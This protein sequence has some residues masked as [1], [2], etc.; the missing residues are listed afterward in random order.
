MKCSYARPWLLAVSS[1]PAL[2]VAV[3]QHLQDCPD[4]RVQLQ[5]LLCI[6]RDVKNLPVPPESPDA[7][8]RFRMLLQQTP[9]NTASQQPKSASRGR[10]KWDYAVRA[11]AAALLLGVGLGWWLAAHRENV[12]PRDGESTY[13]HGESQIVIRTLDNDLRLAETFAPQEQVQALAGMAGDLHCEALAL[14]K[15]G[16]FDELKQV[17][18]L[19]QQVVRGAIVRRAG[20]LSVQ[21]R[22]V[23]LAPVV[24]QLEEAETA[25][26]RFAAETLPTAGDSLRSMGESAR[27]TIQV[28]QSD[29]QAAPEL[30][31]P[32]RAD[33]SGAL[34]NALVMNG[35][36]LAETDDPLRR[37]DYC[38][39]MAHH[40]V[41]T[42]LQASAKGNTDDASNLGKY[43]GELL[44]RGVA[45]NLDRVPA[46]E[47]VGPRLLEWEKVGQRASAAS[48]AL[49]RNLERAP[50]PAQAGLQRAMEASKHG[51]ERAM[52][53]GNGKG[54]GRPFGLP[55]HD[56]DHP[57]KGKPEDKDQPG[58]GKSFVPPGQEKKK[59]KDEGPGQTKGN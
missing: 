18:G 38:S 39:D 16:R 37:A 44:D 34:L 9:Q 48:A 10:T 51:R 45:A 15:Q 22:A 12:A 20:A 36:F 56:K 42:I 41:Q 6:H 50:A 19:Y 40:L 5:R 3:Q 1:E 11:A 4:C 23:V 52:H 28:L 59:L 43:L 33:T 25:A 13:P 26:K 55:G 17:A 54:K 7:R 35:L 14:A 2:P 8:A 53:A 31:Q 24:Q 32:A 30:M 29:P 47:L 27:Q 57:G 46:S 58:K 49:Q 21:D